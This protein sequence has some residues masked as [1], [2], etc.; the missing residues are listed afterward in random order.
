MN[1]SNKKIIL[2]RHGKSRWDTGVSDFERDLAQN[3]IERS[4]KSAKAL[5]EIPDLKIDCWYSSPARRAAVTA[6][7]TSSYFSEETKINFDQK[8]YTFSF[9]DLLRFVKSLDNNC[10]TAIFFGHNEA[11]TEFAN[12]MGNIY[13][14]NLPTSGVAII[15]FE[16]SDWSEIEKGK[17]LKIIKPKKL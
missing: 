5:S 2:F 4:R 9:F 8:L 11:Y 15:E 10:N 14:K 12:R 7:I 6:E 3:G 13:L 17:T 1:Q 16:T